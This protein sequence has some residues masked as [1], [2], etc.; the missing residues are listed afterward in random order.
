MMK[1][2]ATIWRALGRPLNARVMMA[3][4]TKFVPPAKSKNRQLVR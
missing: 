4:T 1:R 2:E 3:K